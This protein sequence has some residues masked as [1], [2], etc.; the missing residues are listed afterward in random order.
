[1][2]N[3]LGR[4]ALAVGFFAVVPVSEALADTY[5]VVFNQSGG[6]ISVSNNQHHMTPANNAATWTSLDFTV[7]SGDKSWHVVDTRILCGTATAIGWVIRATSGSSGAYEDTCM[8]IP[9]GQVG[10]VGV[11]IT[12]SGLKMAPIPMFSCSNSWWEQTGTLDFKSIL[13]F[14]LAFAE[15]LA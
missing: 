3:K 5:A 12:S 8:V 15:A 14:V 6:E 4:L 7:N 1:M 9:W 13:N 11:A 2:M 10:C